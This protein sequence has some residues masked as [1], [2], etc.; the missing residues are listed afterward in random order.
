[1]EPYNKNLKSKEYRYFFGYKD[2]TL[3]KISLTRT[4][5]D[6]HGRMTKHEHVGFYHDPNDNEDYKK[7][8]NWKAADDA[9]KKLIY[10]AYKMYGRNFNAAPKEIKTAVQLANMDNRNNF[11]CEGVVY[12]ID[13]VRDNFRTKKKEV[14]VNEITPVPPGDAFCWY[15]NEHWFIANE[16]DEMFNVFLLKHWRKWPN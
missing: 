16:L 3:M 6:H 10:D 7:D 13:F 12:R 9:E 8:P 1:M 15:A 4:S 2:S 5:I 11:F 14:I